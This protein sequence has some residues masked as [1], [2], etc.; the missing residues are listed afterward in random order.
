M[1]DISPSTDEH[2]VIAT[3][4]WHPVL[5]ISQPGHSIGGIEIPPAASP[6]KSLY[7]KVAMTPELLQGWV[8]GTVTHHKDSVEHSLVKESQ[9]AAKELSEYLSGSEYSSQI[10]RAVV[11]AFVEW[12][13]LNLR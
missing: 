12:S 9:D 11:V 1:T 6:L 2:S 4:T 7:L 3:I 10:S 5:W 8:R 13:A